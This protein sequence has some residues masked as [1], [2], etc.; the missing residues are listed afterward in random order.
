MPALSKAPPNESTSAAR[1]MGDVTD[2]MTSAAL[3]PEAF[4]TTAANGKIT[5]PPRTAHVI[6]HASHPAERDEA[7]QRL[8]V[9]GQPPVAI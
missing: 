9:D 6:P 3:A 8:M 2:S 4:T 1:A 7:G 5:S